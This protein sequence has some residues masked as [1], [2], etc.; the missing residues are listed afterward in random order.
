MDWE[1]LLCRDRRYGVDDWRPQTDTSVRKQFHRD[2]DR[3]VFSDAFR[4][5]SAKTQVHPLSNNDQVRDRLIHSLEVSCVARTF[6]M[7]VGEWLQEQ[8]ELPRGVHPDDLGTVVQAAALAHDIGNPPFGH[9]GEEAIRAFW[10]SDF[11]HTCAAPLTPDQQAEL[12]SFEGNAQGFRVLSQLDPHRF[13]GGMRLTAATLATFVKYPWTR[14]GRAGGKYGINHSEWSVFSEVADRVGLVSFG[15]QRTARHPLV[16]LVEAADDACYS[17]IDIEDAVE[18]QVVDF[19]AAKTLLMDLIQAKHHASLVGLDQHQFLYRARGL[20]I[21]Q[22]ENAMLDGF[23]GQYEQ[24]LR[25][26]DVSELLAAG[27]ANQTVATL[28][29]F[30]SQEIYESDKKRLHQSD[31]HAKIH[32]ILEALIGA[33]YERYLAGRQRHGF[34]PSASHVLNDLKRS[35]PSESLP[36]YTQYQLALDHVSGMTDP[37]LLAFHQQLQERLKEVPNFV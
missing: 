4:R 32:S 31:A 7:R 9:S 23:Q 1:R 13:Q 22:L 28:K 36:L 3:I 5:L 30:A 29:A 26:D 11:G 35:M 2:Y 21:D 8:S 33:L 16:Y 20:L 15:P 18:M 17:V 27:D 34:S 24:I 19:D 6:G 25:G 37:Y 14:A 12:R 10:R